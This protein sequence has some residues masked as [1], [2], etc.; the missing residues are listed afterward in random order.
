[1]GIIGTQELLAR[2]ID[3]E[4][5]LVDNLS[6]RELTNPEGAG[7]DLRI[8]SIVELRYHSKGFLS[9]SWRDTPDFDPVDDGY[10]RYN[11]TTWELRQHNYYLMTT[12]EYVNM[13]DDLVGL[14]VP[15]TTLFRSG[16][17]LL[18]SNV[19][20][21]YRG[22]LTFGLKLHAPVLFELERGARVAHI[23]FH[24]IDGGLVRSYEG[25]WQGGR[26]STD[27]IEEQK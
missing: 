16:V 9:E 15:R 24:A 3:V 22:V 10:V 8:D 27:G 1:M 26:V 20:P 5:P 18:C 2:C 21:G 4:E 7:F 11:Q 25:Q 19:A 12:M 17:Q 6:D 23:Q 13:P 14:V